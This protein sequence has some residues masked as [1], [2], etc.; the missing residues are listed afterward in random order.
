MRQVTRGSRRK[1]CTFCDLALVS[2]QGAPSMRPYPIATRCGCPDGP[3]DAS[4][5]VRL[6]ATNCSISSSLIAICARWLTP[7]GAGYRRC[8]CGRRPPAA[9]VPDVATEEQIRAAVSAYVEHSNKRDIDALV[10]LFAENAQQE[11]PV[12]APTNVGHA[13]IR[14]FFE[15]VRQMGS[16]QLEVQCDAIVIGNEAILC[17]SAV[18]DL[19]EQRATVPFIVDH[20]TFDDAGLIT[21]LRAFWEPSS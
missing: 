10:G 3:T 2:K 7:T 17:F 6:D 11:D 21:S 8:R 4:V 5:M 20:F 14:T 13:A 19:G 15:N 18:T 1:F 16:L 9:R 12:G